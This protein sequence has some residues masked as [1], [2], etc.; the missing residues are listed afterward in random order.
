[1]GGE[2]GRWVVADAGSRD[3]VAGDCC[4]GVEEVGCGNV[5]GEEDWR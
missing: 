3:V 4:D 1:M 5:D 2:A